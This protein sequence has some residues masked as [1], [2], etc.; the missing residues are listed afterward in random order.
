MPGTSTSLL[1]ST[2]KQREVPT[3]FP[4]GLLPLLRCSRDAG[5]MILDD[6]SDVFAARAKPVMSALSKEL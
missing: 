2:V 4:C 6:N 1:R 5:A 3:E